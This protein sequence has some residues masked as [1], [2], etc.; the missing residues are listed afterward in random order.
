[1]HWDFFS[2][3]CFFQVKKKKKTF[4]ASFYFLALNNLGLNLILAT[5]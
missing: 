1:M 4:I 3:L 2:A 5:Y